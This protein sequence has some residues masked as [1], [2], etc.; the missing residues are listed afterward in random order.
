MGRRDPVGYHV[1][2]DF[3]AVK[4]PSHVIYLVAQHATDKRFARFLGSLDY[5]SQLTLRIPRTSLSRLPDYI[6]EHPIPKRRAPKTPPAG[7]CM[8]PANPSREIML[9]QVSTDPPDLWRTQAFSLAKSKQ[10][11][12]M[13]AHFRYALIAPCSRYILWHYYHSIVAHALEYGYSSHAQNANSPLSHSGT[14][15]WSH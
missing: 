15:I 5:V 8:D 14:K 1:R 9:F 6:L 10:M 11:L 12:S 7:K 4:K 13:P 2:V 3:S